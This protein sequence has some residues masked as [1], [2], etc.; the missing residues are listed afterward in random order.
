MVLVAPKSD[1][2]DANRLLVEH[3]KLFMGKFKRDPIPMELYLM[4]IAN[5]L[6]Q[7][8]DGSDKVNV[9]SLKKSLEEGRFK[10]LVSGGEVTFVNHQLTGQSMLFMGVSGK[11]FISFSELE[12]GEKKKGEKN[13]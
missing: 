7:G 3:K 9:G 13:D 10:S 2:T 12:K 1:Q 8:R 4:D 6:L 5:L 11:G